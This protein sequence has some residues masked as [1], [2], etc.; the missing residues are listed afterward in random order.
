[1]NQHL[2]LPQPSSIFNLH[3]L[4]IS[5]TVPWAPAFHC[6][7][8]SDQRRLRHPGHIQK[9]VHNT[10]FRSMC[11]HSVEQS[12][13]QGLSSFLKANCN[14]AS[15][16]P[17]YPLGKLYDMGNLTY[18]ALLSL[19]PSSLN[20]ELVILNPFDI[21]FKKAHFWDIFCWQRAF[22]CRF[23]QQLSL[24]TGRQQVFATP[25]R[26]RYSPN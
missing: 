25:N 1:M 7:L 4:Q 3:Q 8:S 19:T 14:Q 26:K 11:S 17:C 13:R 12:R 9:H 18:R 15:A 23:H 5:L 10:A 21:K 20:N 2:L 22:P 16:V 24:S 6:H